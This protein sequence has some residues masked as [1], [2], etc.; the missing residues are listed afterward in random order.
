MKHTRKILM[1]LCFVAVL[2][3]SFVVSTAAETVVVTP[4]QDIKFEEYLDSKSALFY[5][6]EGT[7][8]ELP[9][10]WSIVNGGTYASIEESKGNRKGAGPIYSN[11]TSSDHFYTF[12]MS[13]KSG[14]E[15]VYACPVFANTSAARDPSDGFITEFDLTSLPFLSGGTLNEATGEMEGQVETFNPPGSIT[16]EFLNVNSTAQGQVTA[17]KITPGSKDYT[18]SFSSYEQNKPAYLGQVTEAPIEIDISNGAW[19]H[20][21]VQYSVGTAADGGNEFLVYVSRNFKDS[22]GNAVDDKRQLLARGST[23]DGVRG[24]PVLPNVIRFGTRRNPGGN[25]SIDNFQSY[26][27][28]SIHNPDKYSGLDSQSLFCT[29]TGLATDEKNDNLLRFNAYK[30]ASSLYGVYKDMPTVTDEVREALDAYVQFESEMLD[31]VISGAR[32]D[33]ATLY[34]SKIKEVQKFPRLLT[35]IEERRE[36]LAKIA[37]WYADLG[38]VIETTSDDYL[39]AL[40]LDALLTRKMQ[41]DSNA[42]LLIKYMTRYEKAPAN[43]AAI[44][45]SH[46][47]NALQYSDLL[48]T[49][50][51]LL[52]EGDPDGSAL[53]EKA[54][55][56]FAYAT[57][58]VDADIK[59]VN[60]DRFVRIMGYFNGTTEND[61]YA[62][63][64]GYYENYWYIARSALSEVMEDGTP[65]YNISYVGFFAAKELYDKVNAYFWEEL[66]LEHISVL[67]AKLDTFN[68]EG[69]TYIGRAAVC[70]F[71][72]IYYETNKDFIDPNNKEIAELLTLNEIYAGTLGDVQVEYEKILSQNS[73]LFKNLVDV[74]SALETYAE[75]K[76]VFDEAT[77]YFYA[78]NIQAAGSY[79]KEEIEA[80]VNTY[81]AIRSELNL[82][83]AESENFIGTVAQAKAA[84]TNAEKYSLLT[85][86]GAYLVNCD[87]TYSGVSA[88]RANYNSLVTALDNAAS[89]CNGEMAQAIAVAGSARSFCIFGEL[90][91]FVINLFN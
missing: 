60:S 55:Q 38:G 19:A 48:P 3:A 54:L 85:T 23:F 24:V 16:F 11:E 20:I 10:I 29:M 65:A 71:V 75:I 52:D 25:F 61:W 32:V 30:I 40:E 87:N 44:K 26:K 58:N 13:K 72:E 84:K 80:A 27:G 64:T 83:E 7:P 79:T 89:V 78:M 9:S 42:N 41:E 21:T 74:M 14:D 46:Y 56:T 86:A 53:L 2:V 59:N 88:A 82:I 49:P 77:N 34:L 22:E 70:R 33:N 63:K 67:R 31:G 57:A 17:F 35:N 37:D 12:D 68:E 90:V 47:L 1:T 5:G 51:Q 45:K 18:L 73:V 36:E 50:E 8:N 4:G 6:F 76:P 62:D 91:D 69:V 39:A 43:A 15:D 66:Q 28:R 81:E